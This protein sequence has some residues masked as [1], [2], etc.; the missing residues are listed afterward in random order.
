MP[1]I[2]P[3]IAAAFWACAAFSISAAARGSSGRSFISVR[4]P[5]DGGG[6]VPSIPLL[7]PRQHEPSAL[8][9]G[10]AT[11]GDKPSF[12]ARRANWRSSNGDLSVSIF[13][14]CR[15]RS[16]FVILLTSHALLNSA[17]PLRYPGLCDRRPFRFGD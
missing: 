7:P 5:E 15:V 14:S 6:E 17:A 9:F 4:I 1:L 10:M 13:A 3:E 8:Y 12:F 2:W 16:Q 11:V